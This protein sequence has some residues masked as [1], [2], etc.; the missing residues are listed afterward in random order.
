MIR[1]IPISDELKLILVCVVGIGYGLAVFV[2]IVLLKWGWRAITGKRPITG[3]RKK[4][5]SPA[6]FYI[7]I[8]LFGCMGIL[9]LVKGMR[10]FTLLFGLFASAFLVGLA[11]YRRGWRG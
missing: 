8:A 5:N 4:I 6:H 7:G 11:A 2:P 9:A 1:W 3:E 10:I